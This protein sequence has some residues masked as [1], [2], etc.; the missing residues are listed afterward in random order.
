[1]KLPLKLNEVISLW[2]KFLESLKYF[3]DCILYYQTIRK[4]LKSSDKKFMILLHCS[5]I[6]IEYHIFFKAT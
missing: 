4:A 1:M 6:W 2:K 5:N 3:N